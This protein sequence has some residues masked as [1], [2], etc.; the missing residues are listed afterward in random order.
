[1]STGTVKLVA[2]ISPALK[3]SL[4][5]TAK[6]LGI[7]RRRAIEVAIAD[8]IVRNVSKGAKGE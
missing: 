4:D 2:D 1:M 8:Y 3:S 7:T 5:K 6:R